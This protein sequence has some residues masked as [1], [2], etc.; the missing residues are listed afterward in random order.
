MKKKITFYLVG[1]VLVFVGFKTV[2]AGIV[3]EGKIESLMANH[4]QISMDILIRQA[5]S[6]EEYMPITGQT[7]VSGQVEVMADKAADQ[8]A[9]VEY[10][11]N[12]LYYTAGYGPLYQVTIDSADLP[13]GWN[14]LLVV[15]YQGKG[16]MK[17]IKQVFFKVDNNK[18]LEERAVRSGNT[19]ALGARPL[20]NRNYIPVLMYHHFQ[21]NI[22]KKQESA[23]VHPDLFE[24]QLLTLIQHGYTPI[25]FKDL[26]LYLQGKGGLPLK[27]LIITA[28]DGYLNNYQ[29]AFPI[30]KKHQIPA[31][32]FITTRY[33]GV[34]TSFAHFTWEQ[35]REMENSG[36]IDIQSHTHGHE[37]LNRIPDD[38]VRHQ[39][40]VSFALIEEKLGKRDVKVLAYPQF[41]NDKR[42]RQIL[43]DQGVELQVTALAKQNNPTSQ[44]TNIQRIHVA[45]NTSPEDLVRKIKKLTQ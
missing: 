11:L 28:D 1:L 40:D 23:A 39:V 16:K 41:Y 45:N 10:K 25:N 42:T 34:Q 12:G 5:Q 29:K 7:I 43:L 35:A 44:P 13:D 20:Y 33:I 27:P 22:S 8:Y 6:D 9:Y 24:K 32:F 31:T 18:K 38:E 14:Q 21:E 3:G 19:Y 4:N 17:G 2:E 15:A 26:N 37:L 36:L 30:L